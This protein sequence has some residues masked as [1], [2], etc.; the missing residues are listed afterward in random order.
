MGIPSVHDSIEIHE[1]FFLV[2][3]Y[4]NWSWVAGDRRTLG[5]CLLLEC[6]AMLV[7]LWVPISTI[8]VDPVV[9]MTAD[10]IVLVSST[11]PPC[12]GVNWR[13]QRHT[14]KAQ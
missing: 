14:E 9:T 13:Q 8:S 4:S 3:M 11:H 12:S 6:G 5:E 2:L 7:Q 1:H 10:T